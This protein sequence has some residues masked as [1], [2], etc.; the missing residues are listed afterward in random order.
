MNPEELMFIKICD[1]YKHYWYLALYCHYL[2][3]SRTGK[4]YTYLFVD[5]AQDL[6]PSELEL[7]YKLNS[8]VEEIDAIPEVIDYVED[9]NGRMVLAGSNQRQTKHRL[10]TP[11]MN[12]FGDINQMI[13]EHGIRSWDDV[14]FIAEKYEL[15]ENF[16]NTNQIVDFC[17]MHL[18][19]SMQSVGVDM[20][21]VL[22][23]DS[24]ASLGNRDIRSIKVG[25]IY[26][27]KDDYAVADLTYLLRTMEFSEY[28]IYTVKAVKG[29]EFREVIVFDRDMSANEKYIAYT[30]ALAK[31]TVI[32]ELPHVTD[33]S[34]P[35]YVEGEETE[36]LE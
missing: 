3:R 21:T 14:R 33:D 30:R 26:V 18:P 13:T 22:C 27:V 16:R 24:L 31:L 12:V 36:E 17:N 32:K 28:S 4:P 6:S 25:G 7:I 29:L 10:H 23:F 11:R 35:L 19:V 20:D 9:S 34:V 8:Y 2:T 1:L 5:E 15:T